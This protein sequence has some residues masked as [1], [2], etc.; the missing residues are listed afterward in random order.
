MEKVNQ[1]LDELFRTLE[2]TY[3]EDKNAQESFNVF[4]TFRIQRSELA[5]SAWI[6]YLLN[7]NEKHGCKDLFLRLFLK[8]FNLQENFVTKAM[9]KMVEREIGPIDKDYE[10]GGRIDIIIHDPDANNAIIFE[11]KISADDQP[12]QLYRY[13]KYAKI[14]EGKFNDFRIFYLTLLKSKPSID[15]IKGEDN[16]IGKCGELQDGTDF[17]RISYIDD[18]KNWLQDCM[19]N[20]DESK[21]VRSIIG[22]SINEID[23]ICRQTV[24]DE[25]F[26]RQVEK[27]L[28]DNGK[29]SIEEKLKV[30]KNTKFEK[31]QKCNEQLSSLI[32]IYQR[33]LFEEMINTIVR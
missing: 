24:V 17:F 31:Y 29:K 5:W 27:V 25:D 14:G 18:I 11:N 8:Q 22:Q 1:Q 20:C 32:K 2:L 23:S 12:K 7:P 10:K 16:T 26:R 4:E 6:A 33:D 15:A 9:G 28:N 3:Q 13:Y 19:D 21:P 30:L